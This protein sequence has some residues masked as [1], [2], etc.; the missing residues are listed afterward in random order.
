MS[1]PIIMYR[2][3]RKAGNDTNTMRI[4]AM[5][6]PGRMLAD[7]AGM[8]CE[9]GDGDFGLVD[10]PIPFNQESRPRYRIGS[11]LDF[12]T[13]SPTGS[14]SLYENGALDFVSLPEGDIRWSA[15]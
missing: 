12:Q 7:V 11:Q 6:Q 4:R 2:A 8:P 1:Q 10:C 15:R 3:A 14:A 13:H 9:A 5:I